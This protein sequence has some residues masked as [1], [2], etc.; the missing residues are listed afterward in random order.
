MEGNAW[1]LCVF[2]ETLAWISWLT[3][4]CSYNQLLR[5]EG[6]KAQN[7]LVF[8]STVPDINS[9]PQNTV[10]PGCSDQQT[11][12]KNEDQSFLAKPLLWKSRKVKQKHV[13]MTCD[14]PGAKKMMAFRQAYSISLM[15]SS[16]RGLTS[17]TSTRAASLDI[18]CSGPF[19]EITKSFPEGINDSCDLC[20]QM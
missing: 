20:S 11:H 9:F 19:T 4:L 10:K 13:A 8:A 15:S 3:W 7:S 1:P 17:S 18:S 2:V 16:L 14:S 6:N 5:P 12:A